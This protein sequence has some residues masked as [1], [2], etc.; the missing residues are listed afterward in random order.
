MTTR[1]PW[2]IVLFAVLVLILAGLACAFPAEVK[3]DDGL[4]PSAIDGGYAVLDVKDAGCDCETHHVSG[5]LKYTD[6]QGPERVHFTGKVDHLLD[7]GCRIPAE[8]NLWATGTYK[9]DR[10]PDIGTFSVGLFDDQSPDYDAEK[11]ADCQLCWRIWLEGGI[12]D[13][14]QNW[15]CTLVNEDALTWVDHPPDSSCGP[16]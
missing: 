14:Y 11:C 9:P 12:F 8:T 5:K 2:S 10:S 16:D 4:I 7:P 13:G 6:G 15:A 3:I 1:K